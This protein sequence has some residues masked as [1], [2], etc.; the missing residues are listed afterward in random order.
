[1][2]K[3]RKAKCKEKLT[4]TDTTP[5]LPAVGSYYVPANDRVHKKTAHAWKVAPLLLFCLK[6]LQL[7]GDWVK[8]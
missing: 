7:D 1:M 2:L 3:K 5:D 8:Q 6:I 4:H